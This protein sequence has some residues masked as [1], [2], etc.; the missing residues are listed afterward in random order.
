[1]VFMIEDV[2]VVPWVVHMS[3]VY[4]EVV[5]LVAVVTV[6]HYMWCCAA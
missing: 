2:G 5:V 6:V 3:R 4:V 1:M